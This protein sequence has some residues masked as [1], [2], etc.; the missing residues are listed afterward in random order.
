[1][2]MKLF[3]VSLAM[4]TLMVLSVPM[5]TQAANSA[6][7][8]NA[9]NV[10]EPIGN[11]VAPE[12]YGKATFN[13]SGKTLDLIFYGGKVTPLKEYKLTCGES[14]LATGNADKDGNLIMAASVTDATILRAISENAERKFDLWQANQRLARS[15]DIFEFTYTGK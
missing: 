12:A 14:V 9:E 3:L 5:L 10:L 4:V 8:G 13:A 11:K 1:M 7:S 15:A 2:R 6:K